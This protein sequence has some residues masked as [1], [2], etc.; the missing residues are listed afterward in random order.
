MFTKFR[1]EGFNG[2]ALEFSPFFENKLAVFSAANFGI[3]GNGRLWVI[4][5]EP[6]GAVVERFYDTQDG[7]F[8]GCWS[9][10][11]ENQLVTSSGDGSVKLWDLS[12]AD[13]PIRNWQEHTREDTFLTGSW[14]QTIK[15]VRS[16]SS[17]TC[18][19]LTKY[20]QWNPE[21]PNSLRTFHEH[22]HCVYQT[23]WAPHSGDIFMSASGDQTMK[24]WDLRSPKSTSSIRGHSNEILALDWNKYDPNLVASGS[25]DQT[26]KIWDLRYAQREMMVLRGH[27]YA[28][29]RVKF[30]PHSGCVLAS[31]SYDMTM[32]IWDT[33]RGQ[34]DSLVHVH[35]E[36][37][38]FVLG[39]DMNMFIEGR[40]ATC[41]WDET[42]HIMDIPV[43]AAK[44]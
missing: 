9:E 33:S 37:T 39:V 18:M 23:I 14:D 40:V 22:S 27:E 1:T 43:L 4:N 28:V 16:S 2:Y 34:N 26:I 31:T 5:V 3:A 6:N 20:L 19:Y 13:F 44:R 7:V 21:L 17:Q 24:L 12:L 38:E 15:L 29:R 36:H 42:V 32:R 11:H 35:N 8:D 41:A 10:V 30:S 25:V